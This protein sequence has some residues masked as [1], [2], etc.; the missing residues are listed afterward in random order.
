MNLKIFDVR[1]L[2]EETAVLMGRRNMEC[3]TDTNPRPASA[4]G[5][6]H[7]QESKEETC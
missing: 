6:M 2:M 4:P 5:S 7:T 3:L 1:F